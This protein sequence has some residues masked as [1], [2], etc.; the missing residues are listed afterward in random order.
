MFGSFANVAIYRLPRGLSIVSPCSACPRCTRPITWYDNLPLF[1]YLF[2]RGRCRHCGERISGRYPLVEAAVGA[3]WVL[4]FLRIGW[5]AELPAFLAFGTV[6][7][8]LSAIDLEH[9][10]LP[11][12]VLGPAAVL[13]LVLLVGAGGLSG[14]WFRMLQ[15]LLGAAAYGVPMFLIALAVPAG[16]GGG[17]VK[18]APY[19]GLHLGWFGLSTVFVGAF[20]AFLLGGIS[21][22]V[23]I[24]LKRKGRKDALPFGPFMALGALTAVL[25]GGSLVR[26][27]LG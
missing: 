10:R 23:L 14:D 4:L 27:W 24:L 11:N 5:Q 22:I 15:S 25:V 8:I 3:L 9:R 16:M 26:L 17:D 20:L 1:S 2:L 18:F 6:L 21:G 12:R 19:L 7:V 13:G